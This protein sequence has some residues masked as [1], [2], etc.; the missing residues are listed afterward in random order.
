ME[1][2]SKEPKGGLELNAEIVKDLLVRFVR[3]ET[4]SAGFRK[5]IIGVSG[6]VDSAVSAY[7]A[8]E[9]LGPEN[10]V[11]VIMPYRSSSPQS[12]SDAKLVERSW[13]SDPK[14]SISPLW[15]MPIAVSGRPRTGCAAAT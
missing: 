6:G 10:T 11:A 2:A 3:D 4:Q 14:S 12:L 7:L 15:W 5:G 1:T 9:A 8:A 13:G